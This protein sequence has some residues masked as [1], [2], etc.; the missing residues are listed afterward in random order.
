M[1]RPD[2]RNPKRAATP[3]IRGYCF[4]FLCTLQRWLEIKED[5]LIWC[6]GN[7]DIDRIIADGSLVEEQVK[8]LAGKITDASS[9]I[10]STMLNFA[11]GF[12]HNHRRG[13]RSYHIFRTTAEL[14]DIRDKD[15]KR[16]LS[17]EAI[18]PCNINGLMTLIQSLASTKKD[19]S[20][21][22]ALVYISANSLEQQFLKSCLWFFSEI[23]YKEM[24]Q[25]IGEDIM[26]DNRCCDIDPNLIAQVA[27]SKI[28]EVSSCDELSNRCLSRY[29]FDCLVNDLQISKVATKYSQ[30][31]SLGERVVAVASKATITSAV[32]LR[33]HSIND[34][35]SSLQE[36][37]KDLRSH[38]RYT[39][40]DNL[41]S[42]LHS[43]KFLDWLSRLDLDAYIAYGNV[44]TTRK[45][46]VK[47]RWLARR[48]ITM[49]SFRDYSDSQIV[50][51]ESLQKVLH[52]LPDR[53]RIETDD[54]CLLLL[55]QK[56]AEWILELVS[57]FNS[58]HSLLISIST[59]IRCV[60]KWDMHQ[61]A[62]Q[63]DPV[64]KWFSSS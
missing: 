7:E 20:A 30:R 11:Q 29:D 62:T 19:D 39:D 6:E 31:G 27:I 44:K 48:A 18:T 64:E 1:Q 14:G 41:N 25:R 47:E 61:F 9:S 32:V 49:S 57:E 42:I 59:K 33:F 13:Y 21:I 40:D 53:G 38:P 23:N 36:L 16:W 24:M 8:H 15:L 12:T 56:I 51:N 37:I 45:Q 63:E 34:I 22:D 3:S 28:A 35:R 43:E 58:R 2:L 5:E 26:R 50:M 46:H 10:T 54:D 4:Q 52:I 17:S 60:C 55:A